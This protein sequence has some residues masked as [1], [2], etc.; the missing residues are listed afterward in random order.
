MKLLV[1]EDLARD[2]AKELFGCEYTNVQPHSGSQANQS[3]FLALLKPNDTVM[4]M[5]LASVV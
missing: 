4:G 1:V 3:V 2:R 5:S